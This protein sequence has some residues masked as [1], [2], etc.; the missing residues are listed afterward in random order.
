MPPMI[1][2]ESP[3]TPDARALM[4]EL[5]AYLIPLYPIESHDGYSLEQL[6]AKAVACVVIRHQGTAARCSGIKLV[7]TAYGDIM[8]MCVSPPFRGL[9]LGRRMLEHLT[10]YALHHGVEVVRLETGIDQPEARRL[11]ER[12]GF[13][14]IL[15]FGDYDESPFHVFDETHLP[16]RGR[17]NQKA[18]G[19]EHQPCHH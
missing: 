18:H 15:P 4:A 8:R 10:A 14:R 6:L 2:A 9:G 13:Q 5:E 11:Y 3:D 1:V 19:R 16:S 7:G 12:Y 17:N